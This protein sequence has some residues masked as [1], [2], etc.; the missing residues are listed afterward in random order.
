[1]PLDPTLQLDR[2]VRDFTQPKALTLRD[3][4]PVDQALKH[5]RTQPGETQILY[6]Y[7]LDA[8]DRLVGVVPARKLL[9]TDGSVL[10]SQLMDRQV[11]SLRDS[12]TLFD[13]CELFAMHRLLAIPVTDADKRF[14]GTVDVSVYTDEM[15]DLA[16]KQAAD[17]LFQLIGFHIEQT[18]NAGTLASYKLRMPWLLANIGGGLACAVLASLFNA[19]LQHVLVIAAFIPIILALSES[20][21]I[22]SMTLAVQS[23]AG[24]HPRRK[25]VQEL[26]IALLLGLTSGLLVGLTALFWGTTPLAP[27]VVGGAIALNMVLSAVVGTIVPKLIARFRLNPTVA[28]GPLVLATADTVSITIYLGAATWLL[29]PGQ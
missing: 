29:M 14:M 22:Q 1:M 18:R 8:E 23:M 6:F 21:S 17:E 2:P 25:A 3:Y 13:A 4:W 19:V 24:G 7:V 5:L 28:S 9:L 11:I 16:E 12:E 27:L 10:L 15:F 26:P 20:I